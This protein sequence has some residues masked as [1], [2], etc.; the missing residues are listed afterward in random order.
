MIVATLLLIAVSASHVCAQDA[1]DLKV[2]PELER[3]VTRGLDYLASTQQADGS[4]PGNYGQVS[5]VVGMALLVPL[6]GTD[7]IASLLDAG[8]GTT[9]FRLSLW[10]SAIEMLRDHPIAGVG[11]EDR[12]RRGDEAGG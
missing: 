3:T 8:S 1:S 6:A 2:T 5:G 10:R 12:C 9:L 11:Q 7:R 4:W